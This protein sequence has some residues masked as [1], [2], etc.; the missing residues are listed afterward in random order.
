MAIWLLQI[1]LGGNLFTTEWKEDPQSEFKT[2]AECAEAAN[3]KRD[4][5]LE[6]SLKYPEL[7]VIDVRIDCV[8]TQ[9]NM[10]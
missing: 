7:G 9:S 10:I 2:I 1:D 8:E 5:I 6:T 3:K 4:T